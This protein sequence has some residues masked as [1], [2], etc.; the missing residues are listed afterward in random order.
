MASIV[1][2][3]EV[4]PHPNADRLDMV[5]TGGW[6]CAS[7]K[8]IRVG[9]RRLFLPPDTLVPLGQAVR[10]GIDAYT[11][12]TEKGERVRA[13][14]LRGQASFG[15]LIPLPD[16][17]MGS[18][19]D[20]DFGLTKYEPPV[21]TITGDQVHE[22][23]A[24]TRYAK[25]GHWAEQQAVFKEGDRVHVTEKIHGTN[26]RVGIIEGK[27]VAGSHNT[28]RTVTEGALY[29]MPLQNDD[30]VRMLEQ[31]SQQNGDA[32]VILFGEI[33]GG[34]IQ[35]MRYGRDYPTWAAF[36]LVINHRY[37]D[38]STKTH[39]FQH[40]NIPTVP[41]L[42]AGLWDEKT[43]MSMVDGPTTL[44]E[45]ELIKEPFKGREGIVATAYGPTRRIA[46]F[47]SVDYHERANRDQTEDN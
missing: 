18:D 45:P 44:C 25:L 20:G 36:D 27:F 34:N 21:K 1:E 37:V 41:V 7:Q 30:V 6:W 35:D 28:Q 31:V 13:T 47:V 9:D 8:G 26:F 3:E 39:I 29:A 10:W 42:Y 4:I 19:P 46:R 38:V 2:I 32:N 40:F 16:G 43:I 12:T 17:Y 33:F 23:P 11:Q 14:R 22:L 15:A 24:F 5:R